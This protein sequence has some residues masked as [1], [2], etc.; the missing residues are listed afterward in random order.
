MTIGLSMGTGMRAGTGA[1][2]AL[3]KG[4]MSG[5]GIGIG[6]MGERTGTKTDGSGGGSA[7]NGE[8]IAVGGFTITVRLR[9]R[10][11]TGSDEG[12]VPACDSTR[13]ACAR[14]S[15]SS[16]LGMLNVS[17]L[18]SVMIVLTFLKLNP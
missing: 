2:E 15:C 11:N 14:R 1:T 10:D 7:K 3:G 18:R 4:V 6:A 5:I 17:G 12:G 13:K 16:L 8:A 9:E